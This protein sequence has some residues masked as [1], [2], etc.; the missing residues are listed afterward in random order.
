TG[1]A[2]SSLNMIRL[3][4]S[5]QLKRPRHVLMALNSTVTDSITRPITTRSEAIWNYSLSATTRRPCWQ[6]TTVYIAIMSAARIRQ[7]SAGFRSTA[8]RRSWLMPM[9]WLT[10]NN[11]YW[12]TTQTV[13]RF[14]IRLQ[15]TVRRAM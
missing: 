6:G 5:V 7:A 8:P 13:H 15:D 1:A 3:G 9:K 10:V 14:S 2:A 4:G 12:D 11:R